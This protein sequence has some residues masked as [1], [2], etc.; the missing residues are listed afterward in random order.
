MEENKTAEECKNEG[1]NYFK[2]S[3]YPQALEW[4][5]KAYELDSDSTKAA[6][7]LS[8]RSFCHLKMENFGLAIADANLA[9]EKDPKYV[10]AFYRQGQALFLLGKLE[11]ARNSFLKA[12]KLL[13]SDADIIKKLKILKELITKKK[14]EEAISVPDAPK[15]LDLNWEEMTVPSSYDGPRME[16][17]DEPITSEWCVKLMDHMKD[18]KKLHKKYVTMLLIRAKEILKAQET[19]VDF[20]VPEGQEITVCGDTH[21]QYYDLLNIF[22]IN[23]NPSDT[24]PYLFN[25]DFVDRGSFS[26]EVMLCLLAWK[27]S[28]PNAMHLTRGNHETRNMNKLYGFEGEVIAKYDQ[29][30]FEF[31]SDIFWYLPLAYVLNKTVQVNHGGLFQQDGVK[32]DQIRKINRF[33]EPPESGLFS[34]IIWSDP[35]ESPGRTMSKRGVSCQFGP[36]ITKKYLEDNGLSLLVRSH[37]MK[38][39]GYEEQHNGKC[40]TIFSAPNYCDQMG[41]KG[42]FI[43]FK[44]G[45]MKPKFTQFTAVEH[46]KVPPMAYAKSFYNMF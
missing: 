29:K 5:N 25:G 16:T 41:N 45:E 27:V 13:P 35:S 39:E 4:Y 19:L 23:G 28:N 22:S 12:K 3:E 14:F 6:V 20:E 42:A 38:Q 1:N 30:T 46:P 36:D 15:D 21:G 17:L 40:I 44:G 37:E 34:D 33:G 26:V 9:E 2:K 32:L 8:N 43:R 10:K 24:N 11:E 18:Q 7:Y 31:F